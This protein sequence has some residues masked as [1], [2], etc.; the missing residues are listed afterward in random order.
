MAAAAAILVNH[1]FIF[2]TNYNNNNI[3]YASK[4]QIYFKKY[5][6]LLY[7]YTIY[8]IIITRTHI[9]IWLYTLMVEQTQYQNNLPS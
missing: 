8:N 3:I 5:I 7:Y 9:I 1:K 2:G 4:L 6:K